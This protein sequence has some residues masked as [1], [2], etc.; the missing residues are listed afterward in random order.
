MT[1]KY[2]LNSCN[3]KGFTDDEVYGA[4]KIFFQTLVSGS[5]LKI[6]NILRKKEMNVSEIVK[7]LNMDQTAISHDLK[8]LKECGF[9][10][11][12]IN[13]KFRYYK[14]NKKTILP[15]MDLIDKHMAGHCIHILERGMKK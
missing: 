4:Y 5:R 2:I 7:E 9:V 6:I 11:S 13:G 1:N 12:I 3:C 15:I 14:L 10:T 8:R